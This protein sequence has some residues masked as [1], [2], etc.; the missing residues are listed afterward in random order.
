MKKTEDR[1]KMLETKA[2]KVEKQLIEVKY[3]LEIK[4]EVSAK[5]KSRYLLKAAKELHEVFNY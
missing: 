1:I 2:Q 3:Y 4:D 5:I